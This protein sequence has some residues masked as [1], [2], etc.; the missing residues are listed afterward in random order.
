MASSSG[1]SISAD[2]NRQRLQNTRAFTVNIFAIPEDE[3]AAMYTLMILQLK[4][5]NIQVI[6]MLGDGACLF[7]AV[8]FSLSGNEDEHKEIRKTCL[9]YMQDNADFFQNFIETGQNFD[10]YLEEMRRPD[11]HGGHTEIQAMAN[12]YNI[13]I[14]VHQYSSSPYEVPSS[15]GNAT[16]TI[17]LIHT[18]REVLDP[19]SGELRTV[20]HYGCAVP[21]DSNE[22]GKIKNE[23]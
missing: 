17:R 23:K 22:R 6:D 18:L 8:G 2:Q 3:R 7:R 12:C 1:Q 10:E 16:R 11:T 9:D 15:T 4:R 20:G 21:V 14:L 19:I 13:N 5:M